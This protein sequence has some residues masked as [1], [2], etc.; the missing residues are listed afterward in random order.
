MDGDFLAEDRRGFV[1]GCLILFF[2]V[3]ASC[4]LIEKT[5]P[6]EVKKV[7][8]IVIDANVVNNPNFANLSAAVVQ[9][10]DKVNEMI[11]DKPAPQPAAAETPAA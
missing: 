10:A 9:L 1:I 2:L 3:L 8:K 4:I 11:G 5:K 6:E 7:E